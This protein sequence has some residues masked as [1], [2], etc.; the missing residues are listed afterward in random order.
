MH[1]LVLRGYASGWLKQRFSKRLHHYEMRDVTKSET[2]LDIP[3]ASGCIMVFRI[4]VLNRLGGFDERYFLYFKDFDICMRMRGIA[5]IA[6][7][8]SVEIIHSGGNTTGRGSR[9]IVMFVTSAAR[10]F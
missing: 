1:D 6:Y 4:E 2:A 9:H 8:P 10:F 3:I 7:V 5:G